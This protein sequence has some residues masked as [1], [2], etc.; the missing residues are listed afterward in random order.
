MF[1]CSY[2]L[3]SLILNR[4]GTIYFNYSGYVIYNGCI[5]NSKRAPFFSFI[6]KISTNLGAVKH[7]GSHSATEEKR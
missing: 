3:L 5:G 7:T 2:V 1:F 6:S 4:A